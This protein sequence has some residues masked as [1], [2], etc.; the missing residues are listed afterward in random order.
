MA[1]FVTAI[2]DTQHA[3]RS[4]GKAASFE[5]TGD[6]NRS[7]S[8]PQSISK[9]ATGRANL[10]A[11]GWQDGDFNQPVITVGMPWTNVMPCNALA[12]EIADVMAKVIEEQGGKVVIAGTPVISDGE[13]NGSTG[14]KYV[15]FKCDLV[16]C[17]FVVWLAVPMMNDADVMHGLGIRCHRAI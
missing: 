17:W 11:A 5:L 16:G 9:C 2:T 10:R 13:T 7:A 15:F 14:M 12:R 6:P 4:A 1:S 3:A 8:Q